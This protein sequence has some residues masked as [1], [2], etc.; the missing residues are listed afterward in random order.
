LNSP[1]YLV[2]VDSRYYSTGNPLHYLPQEDLELVKDNVQI[3][4]PEIS[5][6]F[7]GYKNNR[8]L[9][10]PWLMERYPSDK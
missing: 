10:R 6:Y 8:H 9:P 1:N 4:A 2:L 7:E 5:E 3:K